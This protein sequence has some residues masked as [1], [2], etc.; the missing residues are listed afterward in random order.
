MGVTRN[1]V[2]G[3]G[4]DQDAAMVVFPIDPFLVGSDLTPVADRFQEFVDGSTTW[5]SQATSQ[6]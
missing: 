4:F 5:R 2:S 6:T 1:A 3:L